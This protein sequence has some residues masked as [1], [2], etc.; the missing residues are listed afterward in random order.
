LKR[1]QQGHASNKAKGRK[2]ESCSRQQAGVWGSA[3]GPLCS[4]VALGELA[5]VAEL[6]VAAF[7]QV[8]GL[9]ALRVAQG[10]GDVLLEVVGGGVGVAVGAAERVGEGR[11]VPGFNV[12][13][14]VALQGDTLANGASG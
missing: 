12:N 14:S 6:F 2:K 10:L 3:G 5:E 8:G 13:D 9:R 4:S 1:A 7:E 11:T